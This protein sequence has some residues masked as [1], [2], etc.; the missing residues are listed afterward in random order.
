MSL[1]I[2]VRGVEIGV[3]PILVATVM[4]L[5]IP[6]RGVEIGVDPVLVAGIRS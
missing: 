3:D 5:D 4:S 1:D 2:P 6:V